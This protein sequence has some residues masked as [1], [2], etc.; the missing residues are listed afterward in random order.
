MYCACSESIFR[1]NNRGF[2]DKIPMYACVGFTEKGTLFNAYNT[3]QCWK[4]ALTNPM[5]IIKVPNLR[6]QTNPKNLIKVLIQRAIRRTHAWWRTSIHKF[7]SPITHAWWDYYDSQS[8]LFQVIKGLHISADTTRAYMYLFKPQ[9]PIDWVRFWLQRNIN[10]VFIENTQSKG[11][12]SIQEVPLILSYRS[13]LSPFA[14]SIPFSPPIR[15]LYNLYYQENQAL[16]VPP[17]MFNHMVS[18]WHIPLVF[19]NA[20][21]SPKALFTY[22]SEIP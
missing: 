21:C 3:V 16:W 20:I 10:S 5:L 1:K 18:Q 4:S 6:A 19:Y 2:I 7:T 8:A 9:C 12:H 17:M 15:W 14:I 22:A 11:C 13:I